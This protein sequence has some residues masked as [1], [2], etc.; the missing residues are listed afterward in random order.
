VRHTSY[1]A[2]ATHQFTF[3]LYLVHDDYA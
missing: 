2:P 1:Q 3:Y